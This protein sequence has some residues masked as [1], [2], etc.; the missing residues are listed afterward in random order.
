[1]VVQNLT[2]SYNTYKIQQTQYLQTVEY[3]KSNTLPLATQ[4]IETANKQFQNG[5]INYLEWVQL[6]HQNIT[7]QNEYIDAIKNYNEAS[8]QLH[9]FTSK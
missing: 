7:I 4:T 6:I 9:Y 8:I 3:L 5:V 1:M 2:L